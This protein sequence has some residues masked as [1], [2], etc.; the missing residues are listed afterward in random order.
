MYSHIPFELAAEI[1]SH[2]ARDLDTLRA[3]TLTSSSMRSS[4]IP[5][6]FDAIRFPWSESGEFW[7]ELLE[8]IPDLPTTTKTVHFRWPPNLL[9]AE[10]A[11]AA[12]PLMPHVGTIHWSISCGSDPPIRQALNVADASL[13]LSKFPNMAELHMDNAMFLDL[14]SIAQFLG[15]CGALSALNLYRGG[16]ALE[17]ALP[18]D[19]SAHGRPTLFDL[20]ALETLDVQSVG[21][22]SYVIDLVEHSPP[23]A[24]KSLTLRACSPGTTRKLFALGSRTLVVYPSFKCHRLWPACLLSALCT[25]LSYVCQKKKTS[26]ACD[27]DTPHTPH[28]PRSPEPDYYRA[29]VPRWRRRQ[30]SHVRDRGRTHRN[31]GRHQAASAIRNSGRNNGE[32]E[33][34]A[35][36]GLGSR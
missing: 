29:P 20:S 14:A 2:N 11:H 26:G 33:G 13:C 23:R 34:S 3:M 24:L 28:L 32:P 16:V 21:N 8:S 30:R 36:G 31:G 27:R 9:N 19:H 7:A 17:T 15:S 22:G 10:V 12:I 35:T 1:A 18:F 6:L 4:A 5:F 25:R